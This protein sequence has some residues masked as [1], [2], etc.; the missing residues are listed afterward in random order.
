MAS[1]NGTHSQPKKR[2][3][4][5]ATAQAE[6][7]YRVRL[8]SW[9]VPLDQRAP[10]PEGND[11]AMMIRMGSPSGLESLDECAVTVEMLEGPWE[12]VPEE[13]YPKP[14]EPPPSG[15]F[16]TNTMDG[17]DITITSGY[18]DGGGQILLTGPGTGK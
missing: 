13:D 14:P 8:E 17:G 12:V 4:K 6:E 18:G 15:I 10:F 3:L 2:D 1:A 11:A 5:W 7:G 16:F 9:R